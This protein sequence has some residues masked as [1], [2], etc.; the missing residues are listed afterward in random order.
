MQEKKVQHLPVPEANFRDDL[1]L[2]A[3]LALTGLG[4]LLL[5][6]SGESIADSYR[7]PVSPRA[8]PRLLP[9]RLESRLGLILK[10]ISVAS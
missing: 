3:P 5:P 4:R 9:M 6:V 8:Q 1:H 2:D 7:E 10:R